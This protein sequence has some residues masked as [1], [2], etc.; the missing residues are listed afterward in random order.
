[1]LFGP[2]G[3]QAPHLTGRGGGGLAKLW[4]WFSSIWN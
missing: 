1:V 2:R 3:E 4:S